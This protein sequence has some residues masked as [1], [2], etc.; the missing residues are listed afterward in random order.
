MYCAQSTIA[1]LQDVTPHLLKLDTCFGTRVHIDLTAASYGQ[2]SAIHVENRDPSA[3]SGG[4][5]RRMFPEPGADF[6]W[7]DD[8]DPQYDE[9]S[10]VDVD[11]LGSSLRWG[12]KFTLTLCDET[13]DCVLEHGWLS[14]GIGVDG[15]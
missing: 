6:I 9:V 14:A 5:K 7:L 4:R 3:S 15:K 11:E 10:W 2:G 1:T 8:E 12:R 13:R